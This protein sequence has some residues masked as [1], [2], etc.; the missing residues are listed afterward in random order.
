MQLYAV[1][2]EYKF[3]QIVPA[4]RV[5][6]DAGEKNKISKKV[7]AFFPTRKYKRKEKG[8]K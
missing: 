5:E 4:H 3:R 7:A 8:S 1:E 6:Q 2:N